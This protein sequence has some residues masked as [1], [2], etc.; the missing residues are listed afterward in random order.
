MKRWF[1]GFIWQWHGGSWIGFNPIGIEF[2]YEKF[3]P[4]L[5]FKIVILGVGFQILYLCPWET[6]ESLYAKDCTSNMM[7]ILSVGAEFQKKDAEIIQEIID[8][9]PEWQ[10]TN[11]VRTIIK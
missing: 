4:S 3:D 11:E 2:E 9:K 6:K 8:A 7:N 1:F 10:R 5:A